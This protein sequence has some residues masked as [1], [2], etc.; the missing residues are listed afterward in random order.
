MSYDEYWHGEAW[1]TKSY[2]EAYKLKREIK[3]YELWRQ[4]MYIYE[5]L[6][7]V[8][9]V[10]HAF[11][12]NGTKPNS[13]SNKPYGVQ[14]EQESELEKLEKAE[15]ERLKAKLHFIYL[16][17]LLQRKFEKKDGTENG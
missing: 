3:D 16:T 2:R 6:L 15:N 12:K 4:G 9:P 14:D 10:L 8:S 5:A 13:Y 11:A 7:D 17:K 1:L